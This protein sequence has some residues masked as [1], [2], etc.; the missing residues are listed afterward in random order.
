MRRRRVPSREVRHRVDWSTLVF[1]RQK[2]VGLDNVH[3]TLHIISYT[4]YTSV[5]FLH[6]GATHSFSDT[7]FWSLLASTFFTC[8][9]AK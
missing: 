4:R 6:L 2:Y 8:P 7:A 3:P 9:F 5:R 1:Q